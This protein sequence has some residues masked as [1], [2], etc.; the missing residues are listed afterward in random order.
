MQQLSTLP[1]VSLQTAKKCSAMLILVITLFAATTVANTE[2]SIEAEIAAAAEAAPPHITA[3]ATYLA[4]EQDHFQTLRTGT[5]NFTCLV[6]RDPQGRF[7]PACLNEE[8]MRSVF[9]TYALEM[10]LLYAGTPPSAIKQRLADAYSAGQIPT[11]EPGAIVYMMSQNNLNYNA[12]T[13]ILAPTPVH[14]MYYFPK[15]PDETF[16]LTANL[17]V[18]L[19]QGFP[20]LS[21]LIVDISK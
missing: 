13:E 14:Q 6:I 2:F 3:A 21:A 1:F 5:N 7:E 19:W 18:R 9:P 10:K 4:F 17:P 16:S 20:H 12:A 8:A 15:M 11:A